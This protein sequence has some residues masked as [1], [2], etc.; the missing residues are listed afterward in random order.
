MKKNYWLI[1]ILLTATLLSNSQ[2]IIQESPDKIYSV[3]IFI[4]DQVKLNMFHGDNEIIHDVIIDCS[5]DGY[6]ID[7]SKYKVAKEEQ[8]TFLINSS[9]YLSC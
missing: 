9:C 6:E 5:I 8:I 2:S 4:E 1:F 7:Y 3:E